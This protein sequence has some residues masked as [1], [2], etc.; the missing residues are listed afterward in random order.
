MSENSSK[1]VNARFAL[2]VNALLALVALFCFLGMDFIGRGEKTISG[3]EW[4]DFAE[5]ADMFWPYLYIIVPLVQL[6]VRMFVKLKSDVILTTLLMFVPVI[7]TFVEK[8]E[9][10]E[11]LQMGFYMYLL[12]SIGMVIVA[13]YINDEDTSNS[14]S[15][16]A[17]KEVKEKDGSA[18]L[19][20]EIREEYDEQRLQDIVS[21]S[22]M[23]NEALVDE[24]RKEL[25]I[26]THAEKIMPEVVGYDND[27]IEEILSN[28]TTYSAALVYCCEKVKAERLRIYEEEEKR[29]AEEERIRKQQEAEEERIRLEKEAEEKRQRNAALWQKYKIYVYILACILV[30]LIIIA[31]LNSDVRRYTKGTE[32]FEEGNMGSAIEWLSKVSDD[33]KEYSSASYMLYQSYLAQNDSVNAGRVIGRTVKDNDWEVNPEAYKTYATHLLK[34][35]FRPY[36]LP[37]SLRAAQLMK[38]SDDRGI[39]LTAAELY[40]KNEEYA[41][42]YQIF[43][44]EAYGDEK[45]YGGKAYGFMALYY[46][47]G[48][49]GMDKDLKKAKEYLDKAPN[50]APF[51]DYKVIFAF[52][53]LSEHNRYDTMAGIWSNMLWGR[54]KGFIGAIDRDKID[55]I[56][57]ELYE[58][59]RKYCKED[60]WGFHG[61][62]YRYNFDNDTNIGSYEG[63]NGRWNSERGAHNGWGCFVYFNKRNKINTVNFGKYHQ[64]HLQGPGVWV[65]KCVE[66]NTLKMWW[67]DFNKGQLN[68]GAFWSNASIDKECFAKYE[69]DLPFKDIE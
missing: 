26:R 7:V 13:F 28:Y 38:T 16:V 50:V 61:D 36:I 69:I 20:K 43:H 45:I 22:V 37:N 63:M 47:F 52:A 65:E 62:W 8:G 34:G 19:K 46:L 11:D 27:K 14:A 9:S 58:N 59:R 51:L 66:K 68:V 29:K 2:V 40:F 54:R 33:Y 23:Y 4:L 35:T 60:D 3:K 21:N 55:E 31:Y 6:V 18:E 41:S 49:N 17:V 24:C 53:H 10:F 30:V 1:G 48:L 57:Q 56:Y 67:G 32:A 15:G 64:L 5:E 12:I 42:A 44:S 39:R 25:E